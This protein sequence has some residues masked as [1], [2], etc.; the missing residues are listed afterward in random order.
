MVDVYAHPFNKRE[1][2]CAKAI[3]DAV[4]VPLSAC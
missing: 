2:R 3:N 1:D 4:A